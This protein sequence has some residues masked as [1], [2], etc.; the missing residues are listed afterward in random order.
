MLPNASQLLASLTEAQHQQLTGFAAKRL[1]R[2]ATSP[3]RQ[4]LLGL[5]T[6]EDLFHQAVE[7]L[8]LGESDVRRGRRLSLR[9]RQNAAAFLHCVEGI[10]NSDLNARLNSSEASYEHLSLDAER[11]ETGASNEL[12]D[13]LD[14]FAIVVRRDLKAVFFAR[15]REWAATTP[16]LRLIIDHWEY[17]FLFDDRIAGAAFDQNHVNQ[18][19][20]RGRA[21]LKELAQ[22][23]EPNVADGR[24]MLL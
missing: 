22:E 8:L 3:S 5:L 4:R 23:V 20:H 12:P 14:L 15:L 24:E 19:R 21:L 2:L 1:Q 13:S 9:N 7:K 16:H 10:I 6:P 17:G 18:V 11:T